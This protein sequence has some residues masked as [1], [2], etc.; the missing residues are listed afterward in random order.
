MT[1]RNIKFEF[2]YDGTN[3][4][5]F[6]I[7]PNQRTVQAEMQYAIKKLT[8]QDI[9][10]ISSGRTDGGVHARKAVVNFHI[11]CGMPV[12]RWTNAMNFLLPEDIVINKAEEVPINFHSRYDVKEKIYRYTIH[13]NKTED[14]FSRNYS[15]HF[16]YPLDIDAMK[17]SCLLFLGKHDFTAFSSV[18]TD[19]ENKERIIFDSKV[20]QEDNKIYF[21]ISGNGFLYKMVRIIT[22]NLLEI[23]KSKIKPEDI[24]KALEDK[25]QTKYVY[26]VPAKG[27]TLWDVKY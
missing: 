2:S 5:G 24:L 11:D 10:I 14:V 12:E 9:K 18:K 23:G 26:T 19:K 3:Y 27:L 4:C 7:Q 15:F 17:E 1:I 22:G 8:N 21:Q 20:W 25:K 6:Q 16:P 13:N